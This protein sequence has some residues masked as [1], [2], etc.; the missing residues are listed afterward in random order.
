MGIEGICLQAEE[1][2]FYA[3]SACAAGDSMFRW[4]GRS[5]TGTRVGTVCFALFALV[6]VPHEVIHSRTEMDMPTCLL[7]GFTT[8][9]PF[10]VELCLF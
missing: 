3:Y 1:L 10:E 6:S 2:M 4:S 8:A 9:S 5:V 7:P